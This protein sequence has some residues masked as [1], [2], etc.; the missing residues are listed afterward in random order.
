MDE[1]KNYLIRIVG[2]ANMEPWIIDEIFPV[3]QSTNFPAQ[4]KED[5]TP[6]P[7]LNLPG[8]NPSPNPNPHP[9]PHPNPYEVSDY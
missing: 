3:H 1:R 2:K 9:N 5:L 8:L 4:P 7:G 6:F